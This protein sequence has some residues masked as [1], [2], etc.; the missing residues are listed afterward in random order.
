MRI[1]VVE[2]DRDLNTQLAEALRDAGYIV[3]SALTARRGISSATASP[4]TR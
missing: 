2:D 3:D 4:T 1:L